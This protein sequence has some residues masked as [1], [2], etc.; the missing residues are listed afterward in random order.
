MCVLVFYFICDITIIALDKKVRMRINSKGEMYM[1][2]KILIDVMAGLLFVILLGYSFTGGQLHE[3]LGILFAIVIIFHNI[4]N[5]KWYLSLKK[6]NYSKKRKI[7]TV[8]NIALIIDIAAI[9]LTGIISSR[10]LF[11][12]GIRI[13]IA[14]QGHA[15]LAL[16]C[17]VLIISHILVH[18]IDFTK[19]K[20]RK[21]V[22]SRNSNCYDL[23]SSFVYMDVAICEKTF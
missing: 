16:I 5:R 10:Y 6:G 4:I 19:K 18:T 3:I 2:K 20:F 8:V 13:S 9:V 23:G 17:L 11:N 14:V 15:A 12:T 7:V 22:C 21:A 1:G